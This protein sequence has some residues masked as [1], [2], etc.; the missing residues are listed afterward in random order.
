MNLDFSPL[1]PL[2]NA[3]R[4]IAE[5]IIPTRLKTITNF[6]LEDDTVSAGIDVDVLHGILS[7]AR[8][9]DTRRLFALYRDI[10][11]Q[12]AHVLSEFQKR[13][14]AVLGEAPQ[15]TAYIA[16]AEDEATPESGFARDF[17]A[18]TWEEID[19]KIGILSHLLDATL[20]PVAV[21][22][23]TFRPSDNPGLRFELDT[24][25]P[26]PYH[27]LDYS[28]GELRIRDTDG[29]GRPLT[30]THEA[31]HFRYIVHRGHLLTNIPD[32]W[33]GPMRALVFW[34]MFSTMDRDWWV[35]FLERFGSPFLVGKYDSADDL[36]RLR[37]EAAFS[38][39][40]RLFGLAVS[41]ETMVEIHQANQTGAGDAYAAFHRVANA[42]KSK[43]IVGQTMTAEAQATGIGGAQAK[44]HDNVRGDIRQF[45]SLA[46][47]GCLR[48]QLFRQ[49]LT[50]NGLGGFPPE[51]TWGAAATA[52]ESEITGSILQSLPG[53]GLRIAD[54][55]I[56][57]LSQ[58][59]GFAVERV[60]LTP[61]VSPPSD[62]FALAAPSTLVAPKP[63]RTAA[64]RTA[65]NAIAAGAAAD[66]SRA[67]GK[68]LAPVRQAILDSTS[69][70]DLEARLV[71]LVAGYSPGKAADIVQQ[72]LAAHA[73]NALSRR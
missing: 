30:T 37:L 14:L 52:E 17:I 41:R 70:A 57:A 26:V 5:R 28:T 44:V 15:I 72:A 3:V 32:N 49:L 60:Q 8:G 66:L 40:T 35:R 59:L 58:K 10:T 6:T 62:P 27:L 67:F 24:L 43:L 31:S 12:D 69:A 38:E 65:N 73:A 11:T 16:D 46:L 39:A 47:G 56:P 71:P 42:E 4:S 13:K 29:H 18:R 22:E 51:I 19:D 34:W 45:D 33:G 21:I 63:N 20:Y 7:E 53:A 36:S 2:K 1:T 61:P 54:E 25:T 68:D 48:D 9:G 23:K 55:A 50:I 64:A